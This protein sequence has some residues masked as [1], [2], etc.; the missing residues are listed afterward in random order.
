MLWAITSAWIT[1]EVSFCFKECKLANP[2]CLFGSW[3]PKGK[4]GKLFQWLN[5][6]LL[7][8]QASVVLWICP[9]PASSHEISF[10]F[11]FILFPAWAWKVSTV[12]YLSCCLAMISPTSFPLACVIF[13]RS[14]G[15]PLESYQHW[16]LIGRSH[17]A[18][19]SYII[20][21]GR[22]AL[23]TLCIQNWHVFRWVQSVPGHQVFKS[24]E[25]L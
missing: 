19:C 20:C 13:A 18:S 17:L 25:K 16:T 10:I 24:Q 6:F 8:I 9:A 12:S 3:L 23:G 1:I 11:L 4:L 21:E 14:P 2:P 7:E 22:Q 15:P 5:T